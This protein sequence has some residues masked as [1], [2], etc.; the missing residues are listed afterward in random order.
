[1]NKAAYKELEIDV[2]PLQKN[3]IMTASGDGENFGATMSEWWE[4]L[5]EVIK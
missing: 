4:F 5:G 2:I 3:D 1:M